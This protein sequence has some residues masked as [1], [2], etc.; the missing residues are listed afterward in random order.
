MTRIAVVGFDV[1][2]QG[3]CPGRHSVG[4]RS[5]ADSHQWAHGLAF[6]VDHEAVLH[7]DQYQSGRGQ[8]FLD[9]ASAETGWVGGGVVKFPVPLHQEPARPE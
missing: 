2:H 8:C 9:G 1:W 7:L 6:D 5:L 3:V 4:V